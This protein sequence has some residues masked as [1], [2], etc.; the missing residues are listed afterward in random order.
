MSVRQPTFVSDFK[1]TLT[2]DTQVHA[3]ISW[4]DTWFTPDGQPFPSGGRTEVSGGEELIGLPACES[5]CPEERE[6]RGLELKG[7]AVVDEKT[8]E[9]G[10]E[11]VSFT[12]GPHGLETHWKQTLFVLKTPIDAAKGE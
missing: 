8:D 10:G 7:G 11:T 12:T 2:K 9:K 3:L 4:F 1:L 5:R 6:I